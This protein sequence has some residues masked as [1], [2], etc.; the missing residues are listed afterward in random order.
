MSGRTTRRA[1]AARAALV[2]LALAGLA[3]ASC[4]SVPTDCEHESAERC[5]WE[6]GVSPPQ[7][8]NNSD[9]EDGDAVGDPGVA[10]DP[11]VLD[12]TLA[13]MVA[14]IGAGLEWSLV[15]ERARALCSGE[16]RQPEA[17]PELPPPAPGAW[18]CETEQLEVHGQP[19]A[20]EASDGVLSLSAVALGDAESAELLEFARRRFNGWCAASFTSF[21][22]QSLQEFY[23]CSLPAGPYLVLAR[24]PRDLETDRWQVSIAILDA[25]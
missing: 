17:S 21:V 24:F 2:V 14:I 16:P 8:A 23:R 20:L 25:G 9:F 1:E 12:E 22:G 19:L 7:L 6:A 11:I 5:R 13:R 10:G 18:T 15:D 3:G 4:R